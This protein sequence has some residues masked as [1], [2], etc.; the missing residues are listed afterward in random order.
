ML[1]DNLT[2]ANRGKIN[3][4]I[5]PTITNVHCYLQNATKLSLSSQGDL[6]LHLAVEREHD[7]DS[8]KVVQNLIEGGADVNMMNKHVSNV[9]MNRTVT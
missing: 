9:Y 6:P 7:Y 3:G 8:V 1:R 2:K 5:S 4:S